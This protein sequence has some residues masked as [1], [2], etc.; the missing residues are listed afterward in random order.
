MRRIAEY[1]DPGH[2]LFFYGSFDYGA[3]FYSDGHI[4]SYRDSWP[5][6]GP[7]YLMMSRRQWERLRPAAVHHYDIA[8]S[9][10]EELANSRLVLIERLPGAE[11]HRQVR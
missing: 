11:P 4:P 3:V 6:G 7:R 10:G 8:E 5:L 2:N 1:R 9:N